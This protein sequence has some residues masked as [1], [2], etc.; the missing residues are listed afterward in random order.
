MA[1]ASVYAAAIADTVAVSVGV[2]P[3]MAV[4][5]DSANAA[6]VTNTILVGVI[7]IS[8]TAITVPSAYAAV[9]TDFVSEIGR[10]HV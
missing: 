8:R 2:E 6:V 10:A 5:M 7:V 9:I 3:N 1:E 4:R